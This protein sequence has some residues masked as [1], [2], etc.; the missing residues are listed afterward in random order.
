ME[1]Y[2]SKAT[3]RKGTTLRFHR[4]RPVPFAVKSI[5]TVEQELRRLEE[6]VD[7]SD[8]AVP[9]VSVPKRMEVRVC[10]DYKV[11]VNPA[12]SVDQYP[13]PKRLLTEGELTFTKA[14]EIAQSLETAAE[15]AQELAVNDPDAGRSNVATPSFGRA[16]KVACFRCGRKTHK[17]A[18]CSFK[19]VSCFNCGKSSHSKSACRSPKKP[20][21][22]PPQRGTRRH[23][24]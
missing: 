17:S 24:V 10:G 14:V 22:T 1:G 8:W 11:T 6:K 12:L 21:D 2:P 5:A 18:E 20:Q 13:L 7:Q 3:L 16:G 15:V 4:P 9:I 19:G 23:P